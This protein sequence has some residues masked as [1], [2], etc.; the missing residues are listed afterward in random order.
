MITIQN[1]AKIAWAAG[2]RHDMSGLHYG[3]HHNLDG[4]LLGPAPYYRFL[5]GLVDVSGARRILEIGT[6]EGGSARAMLAGARGRQP[7][8]LTIDMENNSALQLEGAEGVSRIISD[9]LAPPCVSHVLRAFGGTPIDLLYI[10]ADHR[11]L[12][13]MSMFGL[14]T[15]LLK[16][17]LAVFDD[18]TLYDDMAMF[19]NDVKVAYGDNALDISDI[20]PE[21]RPPVEGRRPGF[22]L[23]RLQA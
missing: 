9:A 1:L 5:A 20:I 7:T 18:I 19:W 17:K 13:T 15:T 6:H 23:V 21:I 14:Y 4:A 12:P 8:L 3:R 22:G 10:D 16:P 2:E 11:Y